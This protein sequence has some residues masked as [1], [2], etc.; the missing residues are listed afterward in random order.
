VQRTVKLVAFFSALRQTKDWTNL[1]FLL[2]HVV[3]RRIHFA[4]DG[5]D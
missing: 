4:Q 5:Q 1:D 2:K 3:A